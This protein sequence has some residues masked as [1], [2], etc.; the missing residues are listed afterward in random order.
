MFEVPYPVKLSSPPLQ[1]GLALSLNSSEKNVLPLLAPIIREGVRWITQSLCDVTQGMV[2][3][4][5]NNI[6]SFMWDLLKTCGVSN[7]IGIKTP[8][9]L[10]VSLTQS[11][12]VSE[13]QHKT[14]AQGYN[15]WKLRRTQIG[16]HIAHRLSVSTHSHTKCKWVPVEQLLEQCFLLASSCSVSSS[17]RWVY[18]LPSNFLSLCG[19]RLHQSFC[20]HCPR[21]LVCKSAVSLRLN[22]QVIFPSKVGAYVD[23]LMPW[24]ACASARRRCTFPRRKLTWTWS[25]SV[26]EDAVHVPAI[27][28]GLAGGTYS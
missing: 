4:F 10:G 5:K 9:A 7:L 16:L 6:M 28:S 26:V 27:P 13:T 21:K 23:Q 12:W 19:G 2:E 22:T 17:L 15:P 3:A 20:P 8:G 25:S 1:Y 18:P 14:W 24:Q 11:P